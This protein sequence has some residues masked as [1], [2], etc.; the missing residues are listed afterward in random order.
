MTWVVDASVAVRWFLKEEAHKNADE[1]L[2]RILEKPDEFAVPELFAFE[3][4]AVLQRLHPD[5]LK[6]YKK[7]VIPLLQSGIFRQPM[8]ESLAIKA[9]QFVTKGLTGYDACYAALAKDMKGLWLT[10]DHKAH[11][12]IQKDRVSLCLLEDLPKEWAVPV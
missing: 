12:L 6:A 4:Y 1:V 9:N 7:G 8:T 2:R 3:V 5:G 11:R 10:F